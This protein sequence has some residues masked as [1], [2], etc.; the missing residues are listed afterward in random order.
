MCNPNPGCGEDRRAAHGLIVHCAIQPS[1]QA[2][3]SAPARH[4]ADSL[5]WGA[6]LSPPVKLLLR[7]VMCPGG[8]EVRREARSADKPP[9]LGRA[10][11]ARA[12]CGSTD[13]LFPSCV[14]LPLLL[15][16]ECNTRFLKAFK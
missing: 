7:V 16:T 9:P 4:L 10:A 3:Q 8:C 14:Q 5:L 6:V 2:Q 12:R 13:Q 15:P 11:T 1:P